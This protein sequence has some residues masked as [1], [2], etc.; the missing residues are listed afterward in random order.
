MYNKQPINNDALKR[1]VER[2][3]REIENEFSIVRERSAYEIT[4]EEPAASN[5]IDNPLFG[6]IKYADGVLWNP[7]NDAVAGFFIKGQN[8]WLR[9]ATEI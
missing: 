9:I 8:G 2:E 7:A 4:N 3:L 5:R 1:D 6:H